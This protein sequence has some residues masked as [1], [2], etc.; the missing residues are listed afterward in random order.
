[1]TFAE[2]ILYLRKKKEIPQNK[3]A[4]ELNVSRQAIYKWESGACLPE[5]D[6][7]KKLA[8]I[9]EIS[10]DV[11]LNDNVSIFENE[12]ENLSTL[13]SGFIAV[14]SRQTKMRPTAGARSTL[15]DFTYPRYLSFTMS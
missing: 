1:M 14:F 4:K 10:Y 7:I 9:F 12:A 13:I 15:N 2:K 8:E 6:K 5:I 3:L 11:L